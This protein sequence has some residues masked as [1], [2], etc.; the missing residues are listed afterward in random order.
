MADG[1]AYQ[2][3]PNKNDQ[4]AFERLFSASADE[5][6]EAISRLE[7]INISLNHEDNPQLIFEGLNSTGLDLSE[8]DKKA[9]IKSIRQKEEI[10]TYLT[11][12]VSAKSS[13]IA[14]LLG[15]KS[16]RAKKPLSELIADEIVAAEGGNRNRTYR[17]KS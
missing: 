3:K 12:H 9:T 8:G 7:I 14:E 4:E 16:T 5:I 2:L 13:D 1:E 6:F 11:N 15:V 10:I 17:L